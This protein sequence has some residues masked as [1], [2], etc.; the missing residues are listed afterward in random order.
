MDI[1]NHEYDYD[2]AREQTFAIPVHILR[3]SR[4]NTW[5]FSRHA[6]DDKMIAVT[7]AELHRRNGQNPFPS[8]ADHINGSVYLS[9]RTPDMVTT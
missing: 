2:T 6:V 1:N 5:T 3:L 4:R 7:I 9:P 8:L